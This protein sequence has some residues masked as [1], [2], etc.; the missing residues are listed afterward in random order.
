MTALKEKKLQPCSP[1][2]DGG[3]LVLNG[4][5]VE[6]CIL[7]VDPEGL[8]RSSDGWWRELNGDLLYCVFLFPNFSL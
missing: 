1:V 5:P 3:W 7:C 6:N 2:S 8:S 4:G